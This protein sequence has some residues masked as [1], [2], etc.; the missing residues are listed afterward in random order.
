MEGSARLSPDLWA[1]STCFSTGVENLVGDPIQ[2]GGA[3]GAQSNTL[4][5]SLTVPQNVRY[6]LSFAS[7]REFPAKRPLVT[8]LRGG[9]A[10]KSRGLRD[11]PARI[12]DEK[13]VS[14]QQSP[15]ET[16]TRVPRADEHEERPHR[17]EA[18]P[19]ERPQAA[20]PLRGKPSLE[21]PVTKGHAPA[22]FRPYERLR[23]R[24]E[25]QRVH[26]RGAR[27]AGRY[28]TALFLANGLPQGRLGIIASRRFGGAVQRNR[29]KRLI[30]ELFRHH[31]PLAAG[32]DVV[33]I[34][35]SDL[36]DAAPQAV[37]TDFRNIFTRHARRRA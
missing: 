9:R 24:P 27:T 15:P 34:P 3:G 12:D 2:G 26:E 8:V 1:F 29:A 32:W 10:K 14:A 4:P 19:G 23:H 21:T 22:S 6:Y 17:A 20:R 35:R 37:Q 18:A 30:R 16:D 31:K 13:N 25:F 5:C 36:L 28:M 11:R 7:S 33:V